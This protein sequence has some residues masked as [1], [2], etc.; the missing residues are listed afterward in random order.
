MRNPPCAASRFQRRDRDRMAQVAL[1]QPSRLAGA[2]R[3]YDNSYRNHVS[4]FGYEL[5]LVFD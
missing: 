1:Q 4:L 2:V 3:E 5:T